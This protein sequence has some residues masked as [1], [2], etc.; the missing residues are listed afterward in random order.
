[1]DLKHLSR[2]RCPAADKIYSKGT[3]KMETERNATQL[4]DHETQMQ[5][6]AQLFTAGH[7]A[8]LQQLRQ[9]IR[10]PV[11]MDLM[12]PAV[13]CVLE[14]TVPA[15][16]KS[17]LVKKLATGEPLPEPKE[18]P[19]PLEQI[20]RLLLSDQSAEVICTLI[21]GVV[22]PDEFMTAFEEL[23][24]QRAE[25][26]PVADLPPQQPGLPVT[27]AVVPP[28]KP[29]RARFYTIKEVSTKL[30]VSVR[31]IRN[32]IEE[33]KIAIT[34]NPISNIT[35]ISADELSRFVQTQQG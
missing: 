31:T 34:K 20:K 23:Q 10:L 8:T 14:P 15:L 6:L 26:V 33:G 1:M 7:G 18:C 32:R 17:A 3:E 35:Y 28:K 24:R 16:L 21:A 9:I 12:L 2:N 22:L 13:A 29:K 11:S 19:E 25:R 27:M 4:P 30:G 5:Q